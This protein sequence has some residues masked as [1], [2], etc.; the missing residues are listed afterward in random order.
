MIKKSC[1]STVDDK[2][3]HLSFLDQNAVRVYIQ[4]LNIFPFPDQNNAEDAIQ[5]LEKGLCLTLQKYPFLAGTLSLGE[6]GRLSLDYPTKVS[7]EDMVSLFQS[8][9]INRHNR[10]FPHTYEQLKR[11]GMP[12]SA[13]KSAMFKPDDLNNYPGVPSSGEGIVDFE[14]SDA[15]VLRVQ[16]F[17]V[18]GGLV[19]S[20][21]GHHSVLDFSGI[22]TFWGDFATNVSKVSQTRD[23]RTLEGLVPTSIADQQSSMRLQLDEKIPAE[24]DQRSTADCYCDGAYTYKKTLPQETKCTQRLLVIPAARI[25]NYRDRLQPYFP[26]STPPTRCNVLAALVWTY[27]TRARSKR[28]AEFGYTDTSVGIA[29]DLRKRQDPKMGAEYMGNMALFSRG[30]LKIADL[31]AEDRVTNSTILHV[32]KKI[33]ST[34]AEVN[35]DWVTRHLT[36]FKS[37]EHIQDTECGLA[38]FGGSDIYI[39]SWLNFGADL[40]WCIPGTDCTQGGLEGRPE[41]VRRAY[42]PG[43]GGMIFLPRRRE[44]TKGGE[45]PFEILVRLADEDMQR[46][47]NEKGGLASWADAVI[48]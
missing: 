40:R 48:E 34:I 46:L 20:M 22:T 14:K 27:V 11:K 3:F 8:S 6:S 2:S 12:P 47:L 5:A 15:P 25:R 21:Y 38:L 17:F 26:E 45:A 4:T 13:F 30:T 24:T 33:K 43:D 18:P 7:D 29:T 42:G 37:I 19:L 44:P 9:Q 1:P 39:T 23:K 32:I 28:L 41:Y 16:A 35:N 36:F 31:A 10:D